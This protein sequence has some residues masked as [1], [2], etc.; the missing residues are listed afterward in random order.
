MSAKNSKIEEI[1][2]Y[3]DGLILKGTLHLPA[4]DHPPVVIGSHGLYS[5]QDSPKQIALARACNTLGMGYFR[6]DHCGCGRSQGEFE[7]VTSLPAR[8]T[9]LKKAVE[10]I[11]SRKETGHRIGLFGSSM[12]GTVCLKVAAELNINPIVT[13]AA[14]LRSNIRDQKFKQTRNHKT[15]GIYLDAN[16]SDFDISENLSQVRYILILHGEKDETVPLSHAE[17]IHRL[18][19]EPKRLVVQPNGD[20]RMS[21][22]THQ[23]EFIRDAS[24]WFKSGLTG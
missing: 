19:G 13:F 9:D 20:H 11:K 17:E 4:V 7:Q 16:K 23:N 22:E 2:F 14:P 10:T 1:S 24:L 5:S 3:S 6:F 15:Q 12:G 21:N 18:A 8:C